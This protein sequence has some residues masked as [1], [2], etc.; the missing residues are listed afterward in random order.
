V[1]AAA[2]AGRMV[3]GKMEESTVESGEVMMEEEAARVAVLM[4]AWMAVMQGARREEAAVGVGMV[5][6]YWVAVKV[7]ELRAAG[8]AAVRAAAARAV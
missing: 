2:R 4:V 1:A 5:V 6:G 7:V 8:L 3:E